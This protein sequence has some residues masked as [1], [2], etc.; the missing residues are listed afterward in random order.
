MEPHQSEMLKRWIVLSTLLLFLERKILEQLE[1]HEKARTIGTRDSLCDTRRKQKHTHP[2]L[3]PQ[4]PSLSRKWKKVQKF[5]AKL[6]DDRAC[7]K[8]AF[9][10]IEV[11]LEI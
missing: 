6:K 8:K 1:V 4:I 11:R 2:L 5:C 3:T 9:Q 7:R 10:G